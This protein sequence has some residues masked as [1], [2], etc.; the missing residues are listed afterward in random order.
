MFVNF[1]MLIMS[2]TII[3]FTY[4]VLLP[5]IKQ[6]CK[7]HQELKEKKKRKKAFRKKMKELEIK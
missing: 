3:A 1:L 4:K 6:K 2:F 5:K 7:L